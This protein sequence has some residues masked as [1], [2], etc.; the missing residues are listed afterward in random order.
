MKHLAI[1]IILLFLIGCQ[2]LPLNTTRIIDTGGF[3]I[4]LPAEWK[5][6]KEKGIDSFVGRIIGRELELHFD[7]SEM[8]YANTLIENEQEFINNWKPKEFIYMGLCG[9]YKD[10]DVLQEK[11]R[12]IKEE[13][14]IDTTLFKG[15]KVEDLESEID[16]KEE[17][18]SAILTYKDTLLTVK[19]EIPEEIKRYD[20]KIDTI[21][22]YYRKL[23]RP[24]MGRSGMT[25]IYLEDLT[26]RFNFNLFGE[27]LSLEN[28]E[29]AIKAFK[30]IKIKRE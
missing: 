3:E 23:I 16:S 2:E 11:T 22:H 6:K 27:N 1:V 10:R 24:R 12:L 17:S 7:W 9:I 20:I 29:R 30:S 15:N 26:S 8:G 14:K 18:F 25:G 4:A 28:Q 13:G 5:Y 19:I 21:D